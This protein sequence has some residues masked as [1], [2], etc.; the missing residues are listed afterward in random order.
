MEVLPTSVVVPAGYRIGLSVL[1]KDY[2]HVGEGA[3]LSNMK[4]VM[5]GCG[6]FMH[7]DDGDRQARI[8]GGRCS[9]H[10]K[11]DAAPYVLLP[12]IPAA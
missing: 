2:E 11:A 10:I 8:F 9:L 4:N 5:R 6:P 3:S 7:D 1:G 12:I